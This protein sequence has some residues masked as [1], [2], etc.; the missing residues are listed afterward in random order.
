MLLGT[1]IVGIVEYVG[2]HQSRVRL[3]TDSRLTPSV[4][5]SRGGEQN[6][7]IL[8]NL[9]ALAFALELRE[10]LFASPEE[11]GQMARQLYN[12]KKMLIQQTGDIYLAKGELHGTS[13]P[14]WRSRSQVLRGIGFNYDFADSEGPARDLRSVEVF[15]KKTSHPS[16]KNGG[17]AGDNR[18][19]WSIP[20][21]LSR[22]HRF[23][24]ANTQ[25]GRFFL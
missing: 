14:L 13:R 9:E 4:R 2:D 5:V 22:C 24:S 10:D 16:F 21:G 25:R 11:K 17:L 1:S 18:A 6:R 12:L 23:Q 8:E 7:Y 15:G 3:I 20:A 19:G